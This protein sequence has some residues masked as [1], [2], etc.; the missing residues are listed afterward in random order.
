MGWRGFVEK[1][2]PRA[3]EIQKFPAER[4]VQNRW[5]RI[6]KQDLLKPCIFCMI[7]SATLHLTHRNLPGWQPP[8]TI[9]CSD[10]KL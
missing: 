10:S 2:H 5:I 3:R 7:V 8:E 6:H 1:V 9:C 4:E